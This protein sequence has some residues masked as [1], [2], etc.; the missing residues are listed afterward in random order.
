MRLRD[1][2]GLSRGPKL[3]IGD[4]AIGLWKALMQ[5]YPSTRGQCCWVHKTVN[6]LNKL[7]RATQPRAKSALQA[8]W[9]AE[10]RADAERASD[11]FLSASGDRY[12][13][14]ADT[15]SKNREA[16][17]AFYGFPA[18]YRPSIRTINPIESTFATVRLRTAKTRG[19]VTC[20]TILSLTF[21]LGQGVQKRWRRLRG[22]QWLD[23]LERGIT[24]IDGIENTNPSNAK[25]SSK[26]DRSAA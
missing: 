1:Y 26:T 15:L 11:A 22:Y 24:F 6:S 4:G 20:S 23:K 9:M 18:A 19:C 12:P 16:L 2:Q 7:P 5:V 13:K 25:E 10:T 17:L 8:I 21:K 14:A 3:A